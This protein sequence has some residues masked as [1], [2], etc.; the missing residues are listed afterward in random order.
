MKTKSVATLRR[1]ADRLFQI[2]FVRDNPTC[3]VCGKPTSAGHHYVPKSQ[4]NNLRYVM[5]NMIPLC[6]GCHFRHHTTGDPMIVETI[7]KVKGKEWADDLNKKRRIPCKLNKTFL[8]E[9]ID[10]LI[11]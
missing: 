2:A 1:R 7:L 8:K 9:V 11:E 3:L 6:M 10:N 5:N 4:S